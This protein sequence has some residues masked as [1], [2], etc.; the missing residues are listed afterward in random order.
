MRPIY[1]QL[2]TV[3]LLALYGAVGLLGHGLHL[4]SGEDHHHIG[5]HV[6]RC[7][8]HGEE[9]SHHHHHHADHRHHHPATADEAER[10]T[11][12]GM[13][14]SDCVPHC[15][16]CQICAFLLQVRSEQPTVVTVVFSTQVVGAVPAALQRSYLPISVGPHAPRGP[17]ASLA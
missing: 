10:D 12:L 16:D 2:I 13:A 5:R 11:G 14:S 8:D 17:P 15:H 1:R 3:T 7:S 9:H 6:V 4:L